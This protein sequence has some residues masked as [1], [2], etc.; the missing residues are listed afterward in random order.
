MC[1]ITGKFRRIACR[2]WVKS[3]M[4]S[5]T[6]SRATRQRKIHAQNPTR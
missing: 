5:P 1:P 4:A 3:Q 2:F 6:S